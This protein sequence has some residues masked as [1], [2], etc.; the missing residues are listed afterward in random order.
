MNDRSNTTDSQVQKGLRPASLEY[1]STGR[2]K[3]L[4]AFTYVTIVHAALISLFFLVAWIGPRGSGAIFQ[5]ASVVAS[6][7]AVM[8]PILLAMAFVARIKKRERVPV[9]AVVWLSA[10][11]GILL[12]LLW[13]IFMS[14]VSQH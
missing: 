13:A 2:E 14:G 3:P 11:T 9:W 4:W 7:A 6:I 8:S 12:Y 1:A 5:A 10:S